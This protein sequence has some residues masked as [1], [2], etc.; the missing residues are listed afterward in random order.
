MY[1]APTSPRKLV[2]MFER[3]KKRELPL[4]T[5]TAPR[6]PQLKPVGHRF[7]VGVCGRGVAMRSVY[8]RNV[9]ISRSAILVAQ[10]RSLPH[11]L[12]LLARD[13][14]DSLSNAALAQQLSLGTKK[15]PSYEK[16]TSSAPLSLS[17]LS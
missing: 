8:S 10:S 9:Y 13:I 2:S 11:S 15:L 1:V 17:L 16:S 4:H 3:E 6:P 5:S 14:R 7:Y 12:R